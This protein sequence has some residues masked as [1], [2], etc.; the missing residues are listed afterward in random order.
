[1]DGLVGRNF[2]DMAPWNQ[3]DRETKPIEAYLSFFANEAWATAF[4]D[5][6]NGGFINMGTAGSPLWV[7]TPTPEYVVGNIAYWSFTAPHPLG[8]IINSFLVY[9]FTDNPEGLTPVTPRPFLTAEQRALAT[10]LRTA[11]SASNPNWVTPDMLFMQ[12]VTA[13]ESV[14]VVYMFST[15]DGA[16]V[17]TQHGGEYGVLRVITPG[18]VKERVQNFVL[19]GTQDKID[20]F[21]AFLE[22]EGITP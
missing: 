6:P 19:W 5:A 8:G 22:L 16:E 17:F 21:K 7:A 2:I 12:V 3:A 14:V 20:E 15:V 18:V 11:S 13:A 4:L 9:S 1:M 10:R